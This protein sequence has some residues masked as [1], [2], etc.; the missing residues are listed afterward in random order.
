MRIPRVVYPIGGRSSKDASCYSVLPAPAPR[1]P[2]GTVPQE[3]GLFADSIAA[4]GGA[5]IG[6]IHRETVMSGPQPKPEPTPTPDPERDVPEPIPGDPQPSPDEQIH[7][8]PVNPEHD[9]PSEI[10]FDEGEVGK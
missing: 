5:N 1:L 4:R 6:Q 2:V 3:S 8:P 10:V 7:D 9:S